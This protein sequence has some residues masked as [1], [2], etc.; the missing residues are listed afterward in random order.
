MTDKERDR[1]DYLQSLV[2]DAQEVLMK[3]RLEILT[4][5]ARFK[6]GGQVWKNGTHELLGI[7][8]DVE[9]PYGET[10]FICCKNNDTEFDF[11][12][13]NLEYLSSEE[14]KNQLSNRL[15]EVQ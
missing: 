7:V 5:N 12:D 10:L 15:K 6:I 8:S 11:R 4:K 1:L 13:G 9:L 2:E 3:E 14:Y